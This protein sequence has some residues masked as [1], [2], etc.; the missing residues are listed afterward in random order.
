[1][2]GSCNNYS[3]FGLCMAEWNSRLQAIIFSNWTLWVLA[4]IGSSLCF[5]K[6][7]AGNVEDWDEA[8][9]G[10]NALG[11]LE[12]NDFWRL[13]YAGEPD[14]WSAKP[15]LSI[16]SIIASYK[17]F[18]FNAFAL[19]FHSALSISLFFAVMAVGLR[20]FVG[21]KIA[22]FVL[23]MAVGLSGY[24]GFHVGR[25]GDTDGMLTLLLTCG[26]FTFLR[27]FNQ[28]N[29]TPYLITSALF[30]GLAFYTKGAAILL[31]LP[32]LVL[33]ALV[34]K[35]D[36]LKKKI[37]TLILAV[38]IFSAIAG[39]WIY[40]Q[41]VHGHQN[42]KV[43]S[44]G[45]GS[46]FK[47]MF[48]YDVLMRFSNDEFSPDG[49][50]YFALFPGLDVTLG[51]WTYLLYASGLFSIYLVTKRGFKNLWS[52]L[53]KRPLLFLSIIQVIFISLVY[54]FSADKH[55]WYLAPFLLFFLV[56]VGHL[57]EWMRR[58]NV[59]ALHVF[60]ILGALALANRFVNVNAPKTEIADSFTSNKEVVGNANKVVL[61]TEPRQSHYLYLKWHAE[62]AQFS[63][64]VQ[65]QKDD[66]KAGVLVYVKKSQTD[67][68]PL[69]FK[70]LMKLNDFSIFS[71]SP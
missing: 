46:S 65:L 67:I 36:W 37:G 32:G 5:W 40:I 66:V 26:L 43:S 47:Q 17:L 10:M 59:W 7:G 49:R 24:I 44:S 70:Q 48:L 34:Q 63:K 27:S 6:L 69:E 2:G 64:Q 57:I 56:I 42:L 1:M 62:N 61:L 33:Y 22:F 13:H 25:T 21:Q 16:W 31:F 68:L 12:M 50:N 51:W 55:R 58:K 54:S 29:A 3:N 8:R 35:P 20:R 11:M 71:Y 4:L 41:L 53:K 9:R 30:F 28:K 60:L 52:Q 39:I 23:L 45:T 18:G 19:R 15:P 38:A 14:S